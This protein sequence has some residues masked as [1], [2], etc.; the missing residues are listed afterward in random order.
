MRDIKDGSELEITLTQRKKKHYYPN[1]IRMGSYEYTN[2][3]CGSMRVNS[4][5]L[6]RLEGKIR[7]KDYPNEIRMDYPNEIRMDPNEIQLTPTKYEWIL[8]IYELRMRINADQFGFIG[9]I[10]G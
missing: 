8:R 1:E 2:Y 4:D 3:E 10:R 9:Q 7:L 5:S 6:V